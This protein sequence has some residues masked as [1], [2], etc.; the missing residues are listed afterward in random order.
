[1]ISKYIISEGIELEGCLPHSARYI[2]DK[3]PNTYVT[4]DYSVNVP[5]CRGNPHAEVH[6]HTDDPSL[7]K[8]FIYE[9]FNAGFKQNATC[10]NHR[11]LMLVPLTYY[12][13]EIYNAV[14]EFISDYIQFAMSRPPNQR[15]KYMYMLHSPFTYAV[16]QSYT[17]LKLR[18][19]EARYTVI[20]YMKIFDEG[21]K[22]IE[23]RI[24]PYAESPAEVIEQSEWLR[25]E[26]D[27][28]IDKYRVYEVYDELSET[29]THIVGEM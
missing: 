11:H 3:Y 17:L 15:Q 7:F 29:T 1:M 25:M 19:R 16:W 24:M 26:I 10:S 6:F 9:L 12:I 28:L 5:N 21:G 18:N 23:I 22:T 8:D 20:N 27:K 2:L 14:A 13:F 4:D